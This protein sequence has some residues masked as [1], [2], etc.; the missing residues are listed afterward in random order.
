L[1]GNLLSVED[2]FND[3]CKV[4]TSMYPLDLLEPLKN[5]IF[6][7]ISCNVVAK[8]TINGSVFGEVYTSAT[9]DTFSRIEISAI[10]AVTNAV[11]STRRF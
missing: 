5:F 3:H 9:I 7:P 8:D 10:I 4:C 6:L 2:F 1:V 11:Y